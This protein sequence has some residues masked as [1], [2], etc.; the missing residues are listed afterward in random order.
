M[1]TILDTIAEYAKERVASA[2]KLHS[3]EEVKRLALAT[4]CNTNFPFE[5]ALSARDDYETCMV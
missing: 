2:K 5:K 3:L 4:N 1:S